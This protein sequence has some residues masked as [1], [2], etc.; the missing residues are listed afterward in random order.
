MRQQ[1]EC[2]KRGVHSLRI[3]RFSEPRRIYHVITSTKDRSRIF[4][5]LFAGRVVI[6]AMYREDEA[7]HVDTLA[8]VVMPD[9]LHWL[10]KLNGS[11]SL[12][13]TVGTMKSYSTR[14]LNSLLKRRGR[15]WQSGFYDHAIRSDDV[16]VHVARYIIANP[17]RA[18]IAKSVRQYSLWDS[19]WVK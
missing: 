1:F 18:R 2:R 7:G 16:L 12:S 11:R 14:R 4:S 8:F 5:N 19:V 6:N 13:S 9:H 10:F 15:I 17:L 3:G